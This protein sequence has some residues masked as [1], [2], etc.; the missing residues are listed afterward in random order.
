MDR[1]KVTFVGCGRISCLH[2]AGYRGDPDAELAALCDTDIEAAR[3][4]AA[5]WGVKKATASL[6][7]ILADRSIDAVEILAPTGLHEA[8][9]V[10]ALE[11]GKHVSVQKPM[12]TSLAG[13]DRMIAAARKSGRLLKVAENF[14]HYPPLVL[15]KR[16][17]DEG[18]IGEPTALRMKMI[19]GGS[20]GWEVPDTAWAWRLH[21]YAAGMGMN[22]FDHGHHMWSSAWYLLGDFDSVSAWIDET[23]GVVDSPAV[24]QWRHRAPRRYGQC[25]FHYGKE[26]AVPSPYYD[27]TEWFDV[28]GSRGVLV[29]NRGTTGICEGS[30]VSVY[31][32]GAWRRFEAENDWA[33]GFVGSTKNFIAAMRGRATP[34]PSMEEG[35]HILAMD[36]AVSKADRERRIVY[37][38]ELDAAFPSLYAWRRRRAERAGRRSF[39]T[40][41]T[42]PAEDKA[43]GNGA[44]ARELTLGLAQR[45]RPEAAEGLDADIGLVLTDAGPTV[46]SFVMRF[47]ERRCDIVEG[48]L[49]EKPAL[50]IRVSAETWANILLGK[51]RVEVAYFRGKLRLEGEVTQALRL[52]DLFGL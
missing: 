16:L 4:C 26:L 24:V 46:G 22:T 31:A 33:A 43:E 38:D 5:E 19:S 30:A 15:A 3:A 42:R 29:V 39:F 37:V 12:A 21:D 44:R 18:A 10:R 11:A 32:D 6:D 51:G 20:G 40:A 52:R 27:D 14:V 49:P 50:T 2:A 8:L 25:E 9:T 47:H 28:S 45:F 23:N 17:I 41:M 1:L 35:R 7:E 34:F 13:A 36:I 48:P